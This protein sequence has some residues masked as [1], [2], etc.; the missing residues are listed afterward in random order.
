MKDK[1]KKKKNTKEKKSKKKRRVD[2]MKLDDTASPADQDVVA[3]VSL[4]AN[5]ASSPGC[6][7]GSVFAAASQIKPAEGAEDEDFFK[8]NE[9]TLVDP[10]LIKMSEIAASSLPKVET[11][12]QKSDE[13]S[14]AIHSLKRKHTD[15]YDDSL[16]GESI[17]EGRMVPHPDTDDQFMVLV[18]SRQSVVYSALGRTASGDYLRLGTQ[19]SGNIC[20]DEDAFRNGKQDIPSK[21]FKDACIEADAIRLTP[22]QALVNKRARLD[23]CAWNLSVWVEQ[24]MG[25][26]FISER[27]LSRRFL[28]HFFLRKGGCDVCITLN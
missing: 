27:D 25:K 9:S 14:P 16:E 18:D 13:S 4:D 15:S 7:W 5:I 22:W 23:C 10:G 6:S 3:T 12:P 21:M 24:G 1:S 20:W 28:Q 17:L 11:G 19:D 26:M 8:R 2:E